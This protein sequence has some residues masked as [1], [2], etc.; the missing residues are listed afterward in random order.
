MASQRSPSRSMSSA[1]AI[2]S[3]CLARSTNLPRMDRP[4][5]RPTSGRFTRKMLAPA[6][7]SILVRLRRGPVS[8]TPVQTAVL[9]R[10]YWA[11]SD[12]WTTWPS[13]PAGGVEGY[14]SR[15]GAAIVLCLRRTAPLCDAGRLVPRGA[16]RA[17]VVI[18]GQPSRRCA[19]PV[20]RAAG[21]SSGPSCG[22]RSGL[23]LPRLGRT[24]SRDRRQSPSKMPT[25][26]SRRCP[27][28]EGRS[29]R[30]RRSKGMVTRRHRRPY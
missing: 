12:C 11:Q 25:W 22:R 9:T 6:E 23:R 21:P 15:S 29:H 3:P 10:W 14:P 26:G 7:S 4:P 18:G 24:I 5:R 2:S 19:R 20:R 27:A 17:A 1:K 30:R 8:S 16:G 28:A 13:A